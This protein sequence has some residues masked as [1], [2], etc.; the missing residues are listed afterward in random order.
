MNVTQKKIQLL[1]LAILLGACGQADQ[2]LDVALPAT[3]VPVTVPATEVPLQTQPTI[4]PI[5][6][7][8]F[9]RRGLVNLTLELDM[10]P[11]EIHDVDVVEDTDSVTITVTESIPPPSTD[12]DAQQ[13]RL[14]C[15]GIVRVRLEQPLAERTVVDGHTGQEATEV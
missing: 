3:E 1:G 13:E 9:E 5:T 4:E 7:S 6:F 2:E 8:Y 11:I 12:L 10:C 15:G 14:G